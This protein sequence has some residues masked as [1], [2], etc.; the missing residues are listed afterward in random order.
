MKNQN[1]FNGYIPFYNNGF[2]N[3]L[4]NPHWEVYNK[5]NTKNNQS[6]SIN[7]FKK[8]YKS[9]IP[10][11]K[12][13]SH[14]KKY[15]LD[16]SSK[17]ETN[18]ESNLFSCPN[19]KNNNI[20]FKKISNNSNNINLIETKLYELKN[21]NPN[22][23]NQNAINIDNYQTKINIDN[24]NLQLNKNQK[25]RERE[26]EIEKIKYLMKQKENR[27]FH[28]LA[29]NK[30]KNK[31]NNT[32]NNDGLNN[33]F[34][35]FS[36]KA[37]PLCNQKKITKTLDKTIEKTIDSQN[38]LSNKIL[39]KKKNIKIES[40]PKMTK[41]NFFKEKLGIPKIED[42]YFN[43]P[44]KI[45]SKTHNQDLKS[46]LNQMEKRRN[47]IKNLVSFDALTLPGTENG[48]QKINQDT[49]LVIPNVNNSQ[50]CKIFGVFDGHGDNGDTLS[51]EIRDYFIEYFTDNHTYNQENKLTSENFMEIF[52]K[53]SNDDRLEKIYN[54]FTKNNYN[55]LN[56]L[57]ENINNKIHNKYKENEFCLKTGS[58]S[59]I[60]IVINDK[61]KDCLNKIITINLGDSKSLLITQD[62]QTI[63]LNMCHIPEEASEKERIEK[64]GG[65][66]SRVD[67]ADYGP[68]R[69]FYKGENY[70][71]LAM[72]RSFG[73][74]NA[75]PLGVNSIPD[76]KEYDIQD[77]KPKILVL[78]TDGIWQFLS[79]EKVKNILL[80]YYEENNIT[81]AS[82]KLVSLALR[83]WETKNPDFIDDITVILLFFK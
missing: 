11:I 43:T 73:D 64:N 66:V 2:S 82:Q 60:V 63:D 71:G 33:C 70:P 58:T 54:L 8:T 55:E 81:G 68:L 52:K 32:L 25:E 48:K 50:N 51:Q 67:W 5:D 57:Y 14:K 12:Q 72:T 46:I 1:L 49:Y 42:K 75:E 28:S 30:N 6:Q 27:T 9:K 59:N 79:N 77:K 35:I 7:L 31:E 61:K 38:K 53:V 15:E 45:K 37:Q 34:T 3:I 22:I 18:E 69:V 56:K 17:N 47:K 44:E 21:K 76:I 39:L 80:P 62:N 4:H 19:D 20:L 65:E 83:M 36:L 13:K 26:I 23:K 41:S 10:F 29:R 24:Y 40:L 78:A 16:K 74:F